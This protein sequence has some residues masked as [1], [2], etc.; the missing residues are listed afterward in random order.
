MDK[1]ITDSYA[2]YNADTCEILPQLPNESISLQISSPPFVDLYNY[3]SSPRDLSNCKSYDEF[4]EH[5][6]FI[7]RENFRLLKPGRISAIHCMDIPLKGDKGL[8]DFP[9]DI[10]R[11]HEKIGYYFHSRR[12]VWKEPLRTAIRTRSKGLAHRQL[13]KDATLTDV[14]GCDYLLCFRKPGKNAD[15]VEYPHGLTYYAGL[16][17]PPD[18]MVKKYK[19]HKDPKTNELSHY[20]FRRYMSGVWM[21]IDVKN[22]LP[23]KEARE[24]DEEKHVC[25]L[26]LCFIERVVQLYSN[27]GDTV[28]TNFMGVGS[29][30]YGAVKLE[31]KAIGIE[32]KPTY[33]RQAVENLK[34]LETRQHKQMS[35][36]ELEN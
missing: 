4:F 20:I 8:R 29:E 22:V 23:Y 33:Y 27:P 5:Y 7:I 35:F 26:Q 2:A 14:A 1:I 25:P 3:S 16:D 6:E 28:L 11:L 31:R 19:N 10:V 15:P 36:D 24:D 9:G 30:V 34:I 13:V 21:D 12:S 17:Q 18:D 32:L